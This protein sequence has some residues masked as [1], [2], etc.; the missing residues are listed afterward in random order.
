[1]ILLANPNGL[2]MLAVFK[3]GITSSGL[4]NSWTVLSHDISLFLSV[5]TEVNGVET[6]FTLEDQTMLTAKTN[7]SKSR[8]SPFF[9]KLL[10]GKIIGIVKGSK[11]FFN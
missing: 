9:G 5:V 11:T 6:L 2:R 1:M 8:N 10:K 3:P 4:V 7:L